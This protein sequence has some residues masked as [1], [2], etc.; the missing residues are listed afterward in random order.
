MFQP[1]LADKTHI[2]WSITPPPPPRKSCPLWDNVEK[3][4]R[5]EQATDGN[6]THAHCML[7][8]YGYNTHSEHTILIVTTVARTHLDIACRTA[9]AKRW[10][11]SQRDTSQTLFSVGS[12]PDILFRF[13]VCFI[14]Y[15]LNL[16]QT[17]SVFVLLW[18]ETSPS[19]SYLVS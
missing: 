3:Y 7:D 16:C 6:M 13:T 14:A 18:P 9:F 17:Y 4:S 2:L 19:F 10:Q 1:N 8:A 5:A 11:S 15:F 12:S